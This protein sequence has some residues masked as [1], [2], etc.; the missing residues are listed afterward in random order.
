MLYW[1]TRKLISPRRETNMNFAMYL[2]FEQNM[3]RD[4]DL[5][6]RNVQS[7]LVCHSYAMGLG[8]LIE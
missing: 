4:Y 1:E 8:E 5:C 6:G 2:G 7:L 3:R